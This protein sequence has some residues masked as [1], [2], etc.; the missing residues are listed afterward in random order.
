MID[1]IK[2]VEVTPAEVAQQLMISDEPKTS[3]QALMEFLNTKKKK[4]EEG[5]AEEEEEEEEK[6]VKEKEEEKKM[7]ERQNSK[8]PESESESETRCIYLT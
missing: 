4:I 6:N 7:V 5:V 2:S 1:L 8:L 3:L